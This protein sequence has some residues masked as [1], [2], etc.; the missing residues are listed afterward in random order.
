MLVE[1]NPFLLLIPPPFGCRPIVPIALRAISCAPAEQ[2]G[3]PN[4]RHCPRNACRETCLERTDKCVARS[5]Q[6][7]NRQ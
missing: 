7:Q 1:T 4:H 2:C 3:E 6:T 5:R